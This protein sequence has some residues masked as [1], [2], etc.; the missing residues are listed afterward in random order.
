MS[1]VSENDLTKMCEFQ[2]FAEGKGDTSIN[3]TFIT[4]EKIKLHRV[5]SMSSTCL[6]YLEKQVYSYYRCI[7]SHKLT[8]CVILWS[9]IK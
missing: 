9:S 4:S 6:Y 1:L 7:V 2:V 8:V 3:L 5:I